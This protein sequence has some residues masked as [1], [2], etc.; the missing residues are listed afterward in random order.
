MRTPLPLVAILVIAS[1]VD[2]AEPGSVNLALKKKA[3][4]IDGCCGGSASRAVDGNKNKNYRGNS[5]SHTSAKA[6]DKV[7]NNWWSVDLGTK[8]SVQRVVLY[9]RA[10]CCGNRLANFK[11][12]VSDTKPRPG[13][14]LVF[15]SA[16][17]CASKT[18]AVPQGGT[19]TFVCRKDGRY[20]SIVQ[21]RGVHLTLCEVEVFGTKYV[22]PQQDPIACSPG[23]KI[24][25][26][27]KQCVDRCPD[28][29]QR[30]DGTKCAVRC[31][32]SQK[33]DGKKCVGK[34]ASP[35]KYNAMFGTCE[36]KT[37]RCYASGDPHYFQYDGTRIDFMG[38]CKYTFTK[39]SGA[40][41]RTKCYFNVEEKNIHLGNKRVSYVK[42]VDIMIENLTF[43]YNDKTMKV[44]INGIDRT[45]SKFPMQIQTNM[46]TPIT[47]SFA[48]RQFSVDARA[49]GIVT[50]YRNTFIETYLSSKLGS[51]VE[52][53][54][55]TCN[56]DRRDDLVAKRTK[57]PT[58][59]LTFSESWS[60]PD[61]SGLQTQGNCK[62]ADVNGDCTVAWATKVVNNDHCGYISSKNGPFGSC[63]TSAL[64]DVQRFKDSCEFDACFYSKQATAAKDVPEVVCKNLAA[65]ADECAKQGAGNSWRRAN[66]CPMKCEANAHYSP[67]MYPAC[68]KTC[69]QRTS[70]KD[71][72]SGEP[73]DGC[74]CNNGFFRLGNDCVPPAQCGCDVSDGQH[75]D[76]G[77]SVVLADCA[78]KY[79]CTGQGVLKKVAFPACNKDASCAAVN[80]MYACKC[81]DGFDGN[82]HSCQTKCPKA[83]EKWDTKS[84]KC[85]L[86]CPDVDTKWDGKSCIP[87]CPDVQTKWKGQQCNLRCPNQDTQW[88]T[89]KSACIPRCPDVNTKWDKMQRKCVDRCTGH[90][91][92]D[93][94]LHKCTDLC[95]G[96]D[97]WDE[98]KK[99]CV[100][101]CQSDQ[102]WKMNRCENRCK[103]G[104]KWHE[105]TKKCFQDPMYPETTGGSGGGAGCVIPFLY[106]S[107]WQEDCVRGDR[108]KWCSTTENYDKDQKWGYCPVTCRTV[109]GLIKYPGDAWT[110]GGQKLFCNTDG[111]IGNVTGDYS[112]TTGGS[113]GGSGCVFPYY[114][115]GYYHG[116]C[117]ISTEKP[118]CGTIKDG[119]T[120]GYCPPQCKVQGRLKNAGEWWI[121]GPKKYFCDENALVDVVKEITVKTK[122]G[123]QCVFPFK[124]NN[125]YY[126]ECID[127]DA[128]CATSAD[129]DVDKKWGRCIAICLT[130]EQKKVNAGATWTHGGKEY[131]CGKEGKVRE[132]VKSTTGNCFF[133]FTYK[134]VKYE[135]CTEQDSAGKPWC[136]T[137]DAEK[138]YGYC[139]MPAQ[140]KQ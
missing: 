71:C 12:V 15:T 140:S 89:V 94:Q 124:Y 63:I 25:E 45:K 32:A 18:G 134:K 107:H 114:Y 34:C 66:F 111:T 11:I 29:Q 131:A 82:G 51:K 27:S 99:K 21:S 5:C 49:C 136:Y 20:V 137:D 70:P 48:N 54:C 85:V 118:W 90:M 61:D 6:G 30:W 22:P 128:W 87:R 122:E 39:L 23:F 77:K 64:V 10:D 117:M 108:G 28:Y 65:F 104:E 125:K 119:S 120:W 62:A 86:Y 138:A 91:L 40:D 72:D 113:G 56:G 55:G 43:R 121:D 9:N 139:E 103:K 79:Q 16:D 102:E 129:Y 81:N 41:K 37:C 52:G 1:L 17:V 42:L 84:V 115:N 116:K 36:T 2:V 35:K 132:N 68:E 96:A 73:E 130:Q 3:T 92:W 88:S 69:Q 133:P 112:M 74:T 76:S 60:I 19:A 14:K 13:R 106:G 47:I 59:K 80:G 123:G 50:S 101:R 109:S 127:D 95:G 97:K 8:S 78:T 44:Y 57:K 26:Q 93:N 98:A 100:P 67:K 83:E 7:N 75:I 46:G 110:F 105:P 31:L 4:Q 126:G 33:W 53:M 135:K 38:K 58:N 24:N